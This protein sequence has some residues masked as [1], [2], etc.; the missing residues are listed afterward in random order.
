MFS[1]LGVFFSRTFT[2]QKYRQRSLP[3]ITVF[4]LEQRIAVL[5]IC[6]WRSS[7][8]LSSFLVVQEVRRHRKNISS[9]LRRRLWK[10]GAH[11]MLG[12]RQVDTVSVKTLFIYSARSNSIKCMM[13]LSRIQSIS[14]LP[15]LHL[16]PTDPTPFSSLQHISLLLLRL[17]VASPL[18]SEAPLEYAT[19]LDHLL[20]HQ[21]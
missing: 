19:S 4:C 17:A 13:S 15:N 1:L 9:Q 10:R 8:P 20:Q 12:A 16:H 18:F 11:R 14:P 6:R 21:M 3:F 7:P 5:T 2:S